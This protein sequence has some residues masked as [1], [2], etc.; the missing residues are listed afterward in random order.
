M[1]SSAKVKESVAGYFRDPTG[2]STEQGTGQ[3]GS[4]EGIAI[5]K[6]DMNKLKDK[7]DAAMRQAPELAKLK[8]QVAMTV[9]GEGLL[10]ELLESERATFF[11]SGNS[12]PSS[13]GQEMLLMLA[14][15]LGK[16]PNRLLIEGH[17]DSRPFS[18]GGAYSN[19]ELSADRANMARRLMQES[20][21]HA[22]Q[23]AA[24]RGFADQRLRVPAKAQ[25]ASNR[26]VSIIVQYQPAK[27][28]NPAAAKP[29]EPA[30]KPAAAHH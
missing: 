21:L 23:V 9:T 26:R 7:L 30:H 14:A 22:D 5:G 13:N 24:V 19:W 28:A 12:H 2:H 29:A 8:D 18:S 20:G 3:A 27:A 6:D 15:E 10:I 4:G 1:S 25:D 16:M 17:T 11:D